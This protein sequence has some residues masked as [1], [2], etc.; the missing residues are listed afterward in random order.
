MQLVLNNNIFFEFAPFNSDNF[1]EDGNPKP[2]IQTKLIDEVEKGVDY[3]VVIST[4][5]GAWR[6]VIGDVVRFTNTE[7][8][9]III[10]GRTKQFLSLV[11]EHLSV[12]NMNKGIDAAQR[13]LDIKIREFTV[14]GFP[15]EGLFAHRWYIGC[16][17]HCKATAAEICDVIDTT[18][19]RIND[20]YAVER[21]SALKKVVVQVLPNHVFYDYLRSK[22]KEG[23]MNKFPRVLKGQQLEDWRNYLR[24]QGYYE[25]IGD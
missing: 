19:R 16:E 25:E 12:D 18:L 23:G 15:Y 8:G 6:Y 22:G 21:D 4:C 9:E 2:G 14:A 11:G 17:D 7:D 13:E 24:E 20:D 1:D 10:T 3:A 5:A